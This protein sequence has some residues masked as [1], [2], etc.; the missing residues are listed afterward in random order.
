[1]PTAEEIAIVCQ[2]QSCLW[3][4]R[5]SFQPLPFLI[6][7]QDIYRH[8]PSV[9]LGVIDKLALIGQHPSTIARIVGMFGLSKWVERESGLL[10]APT[11]AM[12]KEGAQQFDCETVAPAYSNGK[13]LFEDPFPSLVIQDEAHLLEESLGTF[14]GLFETTLE[15]LFRRLGS[16]LGDRVARQPHRPEFPR[17]PKTIAATATVSVPR[18]QFAALYQR[19]LHAVP[20]PRHLYLRILLREAGSA[21]QSL[22]AGAGWYQPFSARD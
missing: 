21:D 13:E 19:N 6:V 5:T 22:P 7:D 10:V 12:L 3:N 14:A 15:Q 16:L 1:M 17:L 11:H 9:L 18:Q 8:A 20:V 4:E 2:N